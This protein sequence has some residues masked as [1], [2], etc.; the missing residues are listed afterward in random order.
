MVPITGTAA[1]TI[2]ADPKFVNNTGNWDGDYHL[3]PNSPAIDAGVS[4]NAPSTD[5]VGGT[6][7]QG[8]A[9]DIGAYE[10]G[11]AAGKWPW[12]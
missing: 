7:P 2:I 8:H 6:R 9:A 10:W 12:Q 1:G 4:A 3:G 11:A 5:I